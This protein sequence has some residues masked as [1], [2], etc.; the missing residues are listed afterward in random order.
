M[1]SVEDLL[2][3][4]GY[5]L[6][7]HTT[8]SSST[9]T[10]DPVSS[11][12]QGP[13]S[14]PPSYNKHH[15]VLENRPG[16][17]AVNGYDRGPGMPY[18][19]GGGSRQPQAFGSGCPNNNNNEPRDRGL[20]RREGEIRCQIDTH[21][22]GES[23]TSDSGFCDGTRGPQSQFKDVSYWRRRGQDFTVLLDCADLRETH[24]GGHRG[25]GRLEGSQQARGQE[26]SAEE[27]Q[28]A[29]QERQRWA[30]QAQVQA[31]ARS[32]EREAAL[33]H[34]RM[35][36]E[37]KCQSLGTDEW[38]PAVN[39]GRQLS[40]SEGEHWAQE[41]QRLH[42]RTP[43]G[44]VVNPRA[45]AKSQSLPRM[46]Q[47][48]SLQYVDI[49]SSGLELFRRVNGHP[50]SHYDLYR[51]PRWPE[52]GRPASANQLSMTPKP[53][54]TRPPRPPSYEMHQ[55]IRG[56]C[57]MLSGR[58]SV[59]LQ[60]RDRTPLPIL[61]TGDAQLDY[62]AQDSGPPGYIPPPSYTRAPIMGG[63]NRGYGEIAVDY[64]YI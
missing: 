36:N 53:R 30:A 16:P 45:K 24:G 60:A 9:P 22:L 49:D 56:S 63:G 55:Q 8:S 11:S 51:P 61:R 17:R 14:S 34:W 48:E 43:E 10:P 50:L 31:Q 37:R 35:V 2:I 21:S 3:S 28:R 44:M 59:I 39:F 41:Q 23:L 64:R 5:K 20:S 13:S 42:A 15:E 52:N 32:R 4:H 40:Q 57:E 26:L 7:K 6:P 18:G 38:R 25:Y 12:C 54:F 27:C 47:P 33:H 62:F 1:Y 46:L 29:A 58:D 19:N